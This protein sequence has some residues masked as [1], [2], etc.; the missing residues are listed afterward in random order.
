MKKKREG[1]D[2]GGRKRKKIKGGEEDKWDSGDSADD[3]SDEGEGPSTPV[4]TRTRT[5]KTAAESTGGK[6]TS[7]RV[8]AWATKAKSALDD[9]GET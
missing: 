7:A 4:K 9:V 8:P 3:E 6:T 1:D 2:D 5:K